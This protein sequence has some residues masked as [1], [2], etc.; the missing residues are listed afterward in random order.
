MSE[1]IAAV[2]TDIQSGKTSVKDGAAKLDASLLKILTDGGYYSGKKP[3][4]Q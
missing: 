2:G 3:K 4:L 1:Q